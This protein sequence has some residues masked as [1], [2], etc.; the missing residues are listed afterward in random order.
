[1][2]RCLTP[3][4]A[5]ATVIA[6]AI[7]LHPLW[8]VLLVLTAPVAALCASRTLAARSDDYPP[9]TTSYEAYRSIYDE[10]A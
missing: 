6:A 8:I 7:F 9:H 1:M 10:A 3:L 5:S 2:I 4:V